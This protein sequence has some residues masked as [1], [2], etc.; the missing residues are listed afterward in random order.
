MADRP[1]TTEGRRPR[2]GMADRPLCVSRRS[3]SMTTMLGTSTARPKG[4]ARRVSHRDREAARRSAASANA[5]MNLRPFGHG[6]LVLL[7]VV[8]FTLLAATVVPGGR[9]FGGPLQDD[10]VHATASLT[11]VPRVK[12]KPVSF[13][14]PIAW[15][16]GNE[17]AVLE[18]V[19]PIGAEG[20]ELVE[21]AAVPVGAP[22][23]EAQRGYPPDAA[24]LSMLEGFP[25]RPGSSDVDGFQIV[26]GL[27]G[28]G[29]VPAFAVLYRVGD[30]RHVAIVGHGVLLCERS[31]ENREGATEQQRAAVA[32]LAVVVAAPGR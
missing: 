18:D 4:A 26:V 5:E 19:A 20:V 24:V 29:L 31:C 25:I 32:A 17:T 9:A 22:P 30:V 8:L 14:L 21:A 27:R 7:A 28:D 16:A 10:R 15:N 2:R 13:A 11:V 3:A 1:R 23:V 6:A 12:G